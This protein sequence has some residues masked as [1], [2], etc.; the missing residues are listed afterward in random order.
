MV[1]FRRLD[2]LANAGPYQRLIKTPVK[3]VSLTEA[4]FNRVQERRPDLV[5]NATEAYIVGRP[6][7]DTLEIHYGFDELALFRDHFRELFNELTALSSRE[8]APRGVVLSFRDRPN[9]PLAEQ[10]F[11]EIAMDEGGHWVEMSLVAVPE[12]DEPTEALADGFTIREATDTQ[13]ATVAAIE[14]EV[15]GK[16]HLSAAGLDSLFENCRTVQI[17]SDASGPVGVVGLRTEPGGWGVIE[18]M[19]LRESV[20]DKL[21]EPLLLWSVAWLRNHQGRRIRVRAY[22]EDTAWVSLL[23]DKGFTPGETGVDYVRPVEAADVQKG[24][25][26]RQAHGTLI[27]FGDWH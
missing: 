17:I 14:A 2:P 27:K 25:E 5:I 11:W 1:Q 4:Q 21:R 22:L 9:R 20:R 6:Y 19:A 10:C 7:M 18:L 13:R 23:R 15:S 24:I 3:S 26:E 8:E 16:P 12:Q